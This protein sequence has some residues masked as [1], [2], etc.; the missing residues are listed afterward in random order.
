MVNAGRGRRTATFF[1]YSVDT[2]YPQHKMA[3][4][5]KTLAV[6]NTNAHGIAV[7]RD[8]ALQTGVYGYDVEK[9]EEQKGRKMSRVAGP[10]LTDSDEDSVMSVGKQL[11]LEST[12]SIKYRTC[13]WQKVNN[14]SSRGNPQNS[15]MVDVLRL[16]CALPVLNYP[17]E[18]I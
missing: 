4:G 9:T 3:L 7:P 13:S 16:L 1:L 6:D 14:Q 18:T 10:A 12:N 2:E 11:E 15:A 8:P 17:E 5:R